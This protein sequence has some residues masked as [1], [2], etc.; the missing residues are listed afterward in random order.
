[1]ASTALTIWNFASVRLFWTKPEMLPPTSPWAC[2]TSASR[3]QSL[4]GVYGADMAYQLGRFD[5]DERRREKQASREE[6]SRRLRYDTDLTDQEWRVIGPN[7][8]AEQ[9]VAGREN[10]RCGRS[11]TVCST[12]CARV[13]LG[14]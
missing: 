9:S 12:L 3:V 8:P 11:S 2:L 4:V 10:G 7:L 6:D 1:M 5:P 13:V 14:D